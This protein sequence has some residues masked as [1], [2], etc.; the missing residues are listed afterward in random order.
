VG[1]PFFLWLNA[2]VRTFTFLVLAAGFALAQTM[3]ERT[4]LMRAETTTVDK[5]TGMTHVCVLVNPDGKYRLEKSFQSNSSGTTVTHV[6]LDQLP[7]ASLKQL[8][9]M[10]DDS[11]FQGINAPELHGG[12]V[13]DLDQLAV[14]VPREHAIQS[15]R[16]DN[17]TERRPYE[18]SLKSLL[19]WIKDVQK[20]KTPVA[21]D[22]N[23][24]NCEAPQVIYRTI[25]P[26]SSDKDVPDQR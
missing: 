25:S 7:E 10:L 1:S 8:E 18:K 22:E 26:H 6:Y 19:D 4:F 11:D 9:T 21:K 2:S 3:V 5:Y 17:A 15:M 24:N 13:Q 14:A 23:S 12:I 20:R 16:F